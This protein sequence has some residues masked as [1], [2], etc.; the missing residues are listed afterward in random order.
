M[1][2]VTN[3]S[4]WG[5]TSGAYQHAAYASLRAVESRRWVVQGSNGGI[6]LVLDPLGRTARR[7]SLYERT[8]WT[9]TVHARHDMTWF[10]RHGDIVGGVSAAS[11]AILGLW[12]L[13][14][15]FL[16]RKEE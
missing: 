4:W 5:N 12:A 9:E 6:S 13:A 2:I 16:K 14:L 10:V 7:S 15:A 8:A 1:V 3:D 11:A